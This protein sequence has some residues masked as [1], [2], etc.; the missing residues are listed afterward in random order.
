MI[1]IEKAVIVIDLDDYIAGIKSNP[2]YIDGA[3]SARE[4]NEILS[5]CSCDTLKE[6]TDIIDT[7]V[8]LTITDDEAIITY[9][10]IPDMET[11]YFTRV[12]FGGDYYPLD[13]DMKSVSCYKKIVSFLLLKTRFLER[14]RVFMQISDSIVSKEGL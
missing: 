9:E 1:K 10:F 11:V 14:A 7:T 8:H 5:V 12:K 3:Q 13:R 2:D 6:A 4:P